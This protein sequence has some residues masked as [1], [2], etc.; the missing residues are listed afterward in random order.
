MCNSTC[1]S[2][3]RSDSGERYDE[4]WISADLHIKTKFNSMIEGKS[5]KKASGTN[6]LTSPEAHR[7]GTHF[8]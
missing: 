7:I 3:A 6:E 1:D 8:T 2:A 5:L 4:P